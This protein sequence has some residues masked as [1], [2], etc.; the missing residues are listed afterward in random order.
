MLQVKG[1]HH[2]WDLENIPV[3]R[4]R[5][6]T[7]RGIG[8]DFVI[9]RQYLGGFELESGAQVFLRCASPY[10]Y[11]AAGLHHG[12]HFVNHLNQRSTSMPGALP[13]WLC[14]QHLRVQSQQ[15]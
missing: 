10:L 6:Y 1:E 8:G 11:P 2:N 5:N 12:P 9:P 3:A 15:A 4:E 14:A 13:C 7:A